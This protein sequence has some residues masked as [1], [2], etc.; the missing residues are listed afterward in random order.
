M[1]FNYQ[2]NIIT[3]NYNIDEYIYNFNHDQKNNKKNQ[4]NNIKVTK[5]NP[6]EKYELIQNF[7]K[8]YNNNSD[9]QM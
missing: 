8:D 5:L 1:I 7:E 9:Y 3:T 6:S 2:N 4:Y